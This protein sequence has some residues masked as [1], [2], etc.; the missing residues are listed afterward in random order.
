M[1][2]KEIKQKFLD[3]LFARDMWVKKVNEIQYLTRCPF[4]GDSSNPSHGHFYIKVDLSDNSSIM[5]N[6]FKCPAGGVVDK[7]VC[8]RLDMTDLDILT[9]IT[10]LNKTADK[11]DRKQIMGE[12]FHVFDYKIPK[13]VYNDKVRYLEKRL[14]RRFTEEEVNKLKIITSFYQFLNENQIKELTCSPGIAKMFEENYVGFLSYGNSHILFRDITEKMQYPWIKYPICRKSSENRIFYSVSSAIDP[15]TEETITI[16]LCEGVMDAASIC[17]NLGYDMENTIT[18]AVAGKFYEPIVRFLIGLGLFGSNVQ[19]NIFAD[20]DA[21]FNK[22]K[23]YRGDTD[24]DFYRK[25]FKNT[26]YLYKSIK[27]YYNIK[28][29]DCGVPK[30]NIVLKEYKI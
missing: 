23:N 21:K 22:K 28:S 25:L 5:Y 18:I 27:V 10:N 29:K 8:E 20:N 24:I 15:F 12:S 1:T 4:C 19:L 6:C 26:K 14:G 30:D 2:N 13:P 3:R 11:V 16:N 9:D 7:D 17:Y